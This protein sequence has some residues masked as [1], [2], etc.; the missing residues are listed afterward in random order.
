MVLVIKE[1]LTVIV[2]I[3]CITWLNRVIKNFNLF[4][5]KL[6]LLNLSY[7]NSVT[8][9]VRKKGVFIKIKSTPVP[10]PDP[11]QFVTPSLLNQI[12]INKYQYELSLFAELRNTLQ[13]GK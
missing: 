6:K 4:L 2:E 9:V 1:N 12:I 5:Q 7:S 11:N 3:N 8:D 10:L 13:L